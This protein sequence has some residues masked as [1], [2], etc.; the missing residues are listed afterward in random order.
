MLLCDLDSDQFETSY[1]GD[2][3]SGQWCVQCNCNAMCLCVWN[4]RLDFFNNVCSVHWVLSNLKKTFPDSNSKQESLCQI[5]TVIDYLSPLFQKIEQLK[6]A[7]KRRHHQRSSDQCCDNELLLFPTTCTLNGFQVVVHYR[8]G[9]IYMANFTN[10]CH[11]G[12]PLV[13]GGT[14]RH[15]IDDTLTFNVSYINI[16]VVRQLSLSLL[17]FA[18][19]L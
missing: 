4:W 19:I 3:F 9:W 11:K 12:A 5:V 18:L 2:D 6:T 16:S 7:L 15:R 10:T 14:T 8:W 13:G 1:R 17:L